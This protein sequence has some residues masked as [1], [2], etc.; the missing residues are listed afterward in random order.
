MKRIE[1]TLRSYTTEL[2]KLYARLE[3][4]VKAYQ[5]KLAQAEKFGVATMTD[6]EHAD[7]LRSLPS[8][9]G[10][11]TDKEAIK[12]NGAWFDLLLAKDHIEEIKGR[13]ENAERRFE[14]AEQAV[15]EYRREIEAITDLKEKEKLFKL[16]FEKEQ[17]EWLKDG[18]TLEGR[19]YGITPSGKKFWISRNNGFTERSFHCWTLYL[20]GET[21]FTSGEFWRAYGIIKQS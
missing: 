12:K 18:I 4:A 20:D 14:K 19:Y 9:D 10:W 1:I 7:W 6:E 2:E 15:E 3:K 21:I 13:I 11:I 16:E 8:C 5:K 17:A